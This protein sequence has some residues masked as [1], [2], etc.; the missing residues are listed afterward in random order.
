MNARILWLIAA[1]LLWF[2]LVKPD[3]NTEPNR[4]RLIEYGAPKKYLPYDKAGH[5]LADEHPWGY[6]QPAK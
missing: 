1:I 3:G 5:S 4:A 6:S 2:L